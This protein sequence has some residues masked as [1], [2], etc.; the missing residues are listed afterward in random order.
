MC[1][2]GACGCSPLNYSEEFLSD[3][4]VVIR[5]KPP[6]I[7]QPPFPDRPCEKK[8][9]DRPAMSS[10]EGYKVMQYLSTAVIRPYGSCFFAAAVFFLQVLEE[11]V[12]PRGFLSKDIDFDMFL[13]KPHPRPHS[14]EKE[15]GLNTGAF[16][17][18][19]VYC[20][21]LAAIKS[22]HP[23]PDRSFKEKHFVVK[24]LDGRESNC[25]RPGS[26][27]ILL[28]YQNPDGH[29]YIEVCGERIS[30]PPYT[31]NFFFKVPDCKVNARK[32]DVVLYSLHE[33]YT[34]NSS[35]GNDE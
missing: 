11:F 6:L 21:N 13:E 9:E 18:L 30:G 10:D 15:R 5:N 27:T 34:C 22:N 19:L 32:D 8:L 35:E 26:A 1:R 14:K 28:F 23:R 17:K 16:D 24:H 20:R 3:K 33:K 2:R 29:F 12:A 4:D 31:H 7:V 25:D